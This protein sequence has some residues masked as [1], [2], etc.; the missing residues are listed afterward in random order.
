[1]L[2]RRKEVPEPAPMLVTSLGRREKHDFVLKKV[3]DPGGYIWRIR[4][5]GEKKDVLVDVT[6][7]RILH[8]KLQ[9]YAVSIGY[10]WSDHRTNIN[11][12][13]SARTSYKGP[14]VFM[15]WKFTKL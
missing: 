11:I 1:M 15:E 12:H 13:C 10:N 4:R 7:N 8:H 3:M 2:F 14:H 5:D 9:Q 6:L